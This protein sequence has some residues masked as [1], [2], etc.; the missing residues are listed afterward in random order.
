M[1]AQEKRDQNKISE[2]FRQLRKKRVGT[3]GRY[4]KKQQFIK[5]NFNGAATIHN[6]DF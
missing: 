6:L 4:R 2:T 5:V 1:L 3:L